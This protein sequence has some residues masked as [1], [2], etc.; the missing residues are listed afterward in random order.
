MPS[1]GLSDLADA[2]ELLK[3]GGSDYHGRDDKEEPDVGSVD[4]PVLAFF[5]F[6]E[7]AEPIWRNAMKEIFANTIERITE[8]NGSK[9]CRRT[10][11]GNDF[12]S[13][14]LSSPELEETDDSEVEILQMEFA[15]II[16]GN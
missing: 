14:C 1:T 2:Y 12:C 13:L 3:L 16:L 15:D 6:L 5:K 8:L 4:L 10:S 11:S 9:E 7:V